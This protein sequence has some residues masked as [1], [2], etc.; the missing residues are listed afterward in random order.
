MDFTFSQEQDQLRAVLRGLAED[1]GTGRQLAWSR[2]AGELGLGGLGVAEAAGG[3]GGSFVDAAVAIEEAGRALLPLP[4]LSSLVCAAALA[5]GD[6]AAAAV[7]AKVAAGSRVAALVVAPAVDEV[8]GQLSGSA[9]NILDGDQADLLVVAT[10][11]ALWLVDPAAQGA[12][13]RPR[14][15]LDESRGQA[16][17]ELQAVSAEAVGDAAAASRAVDLLRVALAVESVG[18]GQHCLD[19]T[20]AHLKTRIQFGRP[21]GSFQALQH[22]V[23][24]L[25]VELE[26]AASTAY[27][28]AW[29]AAEAPQEL[30][31]VAP[32]AKSVCTDAGWHAAAESVQL[33][34]GIGFT[35]EHEAHR[36]LK[37]LVTSR[38]LLGDGYE[39]RRLVA[40]RAAIGLERAGR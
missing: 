18:A 11:R 9:D 20:V 21:I 37:R 1:V 22:R 33:H 10:R 14:P 26:A 16:S 38:L 24:D 23:A 5:G 34:G 36:Y 19:T 15:A 7:I 31:V 13:V 12:R 30:P 29:C 40:E 4:L 28:A 32:L 27:Y 3:S 8:D 17:L 6:P 39:Q 35:W 25:V 2:I